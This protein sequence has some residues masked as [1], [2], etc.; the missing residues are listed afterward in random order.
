LPFYKMFHFVDTLREKR[1]FWRGALHG[2]G[3]TA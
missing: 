3:D 1:H 2:R